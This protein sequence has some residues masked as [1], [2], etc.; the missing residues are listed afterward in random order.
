MSARHI[1]ITAQ[2][3][4][5]RDI[6]SGSEHSINFGSSF[7][8]AIMF[9]KGLPFVLKEVQIS[10]TFSALILPV[11]PIQAVPSAGKK[12]AAF[13]QCWHRPYIP[14]ITGTG[15]G[16]GSCSLG[17]DRPQQMA[18]Q[19]TRYGIA[20]MAPRGP[21]AQDRQRLVESVLRPDPDP[22]ATLPCYSSLS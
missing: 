19:L 5:N 14:P 17:N 22:D 13:G 20:V 6:V 10:Y 2:S 4:S 9:L 12:L 21:R 3:Y 18:C 15:Y 16:L 1:C 8:K 7:S 11:K